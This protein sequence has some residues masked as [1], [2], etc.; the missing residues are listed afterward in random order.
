MSMQEA[1]FTLLQQ[2]SAGI[3][4]VDACPCMDLLAALS[5]DGALL[6]F[7]TMSWDRVMHKPGAD[8]F[9]AAATA[10]RFSPDGRLI[11]LGSADGRVAMFDLEKA[12]FLLALPFSPEGCL[13]GL[14]LGSP[15]P[16]PSLSGAVTQLAWGS[17]ALLSGC[18]WGKEGMWTEAWAHGGLDAVERA[19]MAEEGEGEGEDTALSLPEVFQA[20]H[21][22]V[23]FA[24]SAQHRLGVYAFGLF[25]LYSLALDDPSCPRPW[26]L[27]D[28]SLARADASLYRRAD[29][30]GVC[31]G[32]RSPAGLCR[33]QLPRRLFAQ[34]YWQERV[35]KVLLCMHGDADRLVDL[36][37]QCVRKVRVVVVVIVVVVF[38]NDFL[39]IVILL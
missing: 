20:L 6:V 21:G 19:G 33:A 1:A 39:Y 11:A 34:Y 31:P 14:G 23:L 15:A 25:P 9:S 35:A 2:R 26:T 28:W 7:R 3:V 4:A 32:L 17:A 8:V 27:P 38:L 30:D 12:S 22:L 36:A 5:A 37:T 10:L 13:G 29:M 24:L 16:P 18:D